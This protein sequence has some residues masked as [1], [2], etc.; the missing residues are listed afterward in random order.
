VLVASEANGFVNGNYNFSLMKAMWSLLLFGKNP[1]KRVNT[2]ST[3]DRQICFSLNL[4]LI[5]FGKD[6]QIISGLILF[7]LILQQG[8]NLLWS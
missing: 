1:A 4:F 8:H 5:H 2:E 6:F 3:F 7:E